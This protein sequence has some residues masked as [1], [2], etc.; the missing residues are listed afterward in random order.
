MARNPINKYIMA[1]AFPRRATAANGPAR[2]LEIVGSGSQYC[3]KESYK[4]HGRNLGT[5]AP[6]SAALKGLGYVGHDG[7]LWRTRADNPVVDPMAKAT[8]AKRRQIDTITRRKKI[9]TD[10]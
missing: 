1:P 7:E 5:Y 6:I 9:R 3:L 2:P 8:E 10:L 4:L